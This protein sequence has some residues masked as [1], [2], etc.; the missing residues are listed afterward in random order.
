MDIHVARNCNP[1]SLGA[2]EHRRFTRRARFP[3]RRP[4]HVCDGPVDRGGESSDLGS[5][6]KLGAGLPFSDPDD[7]ATSHPLCLVG[8][9][10]QVALA[11]HEGDHG[12][13]EGDR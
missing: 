2:G 4:S 1:R 7:S 6:H 10:R 9:H 12:P 3:R 8:P 13:Q 5:P 11:L